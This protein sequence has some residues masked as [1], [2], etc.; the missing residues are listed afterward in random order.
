LRGRAL[1]YYIEDTGVFNDRME[2][3]FDPS[4]ACTIVAGTFSHGQ[5]HATTFAQL[6]SDWLGIPF[7]SIGY[8]QGDT[9]QVSFGRGTYASRSATVGGSALRVAADAVIDKGKRFAAFLLETSPDDIVFSDGRFQVAGT[10]RGV[11]LTE[12]AKAAHRPAHLPRELG[13]GLDASGGFSAEPPSFPNGCHVCEVEIDPDTGTVHIDRYA[14]IDDVGRVINPMIVHGQVHG[15]LAQGIGQA[16]L[17]HARFDDGGQ[18]VTASLVDYA[19]PRASDLPTFTVDCHEV[20]C[21]TNPVG[22]KGTG[23]AG[24]VGAPPAVINAILDALR[25]LGVTH[26]DMPATPER[27]WRAIVAAKAGARSA[28]VDPGFASERALIL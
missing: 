8:V 6:V 25:P 20:P 15:G 26:V 7:D 21:R 17:E 23:E 16:L 22:V 27:V 14:A 12:V 28:K 19:V 2:L 13:V 18:L 10:D 3:R 24:T 5:A 9:N 1:I 11:P 4:G